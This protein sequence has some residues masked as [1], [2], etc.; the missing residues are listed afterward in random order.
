M[1]APSWNCRDRSG[2]PRKGAI[3][4]RNGPA[5]TA[6]RH[7]LRERA[8]G[9]LRSG[10]RGPPCGTSLRPPRDCARARRAPR[11][12]LGLGPD[13]RLDVRPGALERDDLDQ[14]HP[15]P[16][17]VQAVGAGDEAGKV[18][19]LVVA[20]GVDHPGQDLE[21]GVGAVQ[22]RHEQAAPAGRGPDRPVVVQLDGRPRPERVA[23]DLVAVVVADHRAVE[24]PAVPDRRSPVPD[25]HAHVRG[26]R[27]D[28]A[29]RH[30]VEEGHAP[31][32]GLG[33]RRH[34]QLRSS[35]GGSFLN[36]AGR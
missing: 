2:A 10:R 29:R 1:G 24:V 3:R 14:R 5:R 17:A 11:L 16:E 7:G 33:P 9:R 6:F 19:E 21:R 31:L 35:T 34:A 13:D 27:D 12:G 25:L 20:V 36:Q 18:D 8:P 15:L 26:Q 23:V 30:G 28:P 32:D 22:R 4:A